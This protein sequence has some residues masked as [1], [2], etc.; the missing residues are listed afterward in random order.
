MHQ[1][2]NTLS[3]KCVIYDAKPIESLITLKEIAGIERK[4]IT[5]PVLQKE[6]KKNVYSIHA[7]MKL[8]PNHKIYSTLIEV[9]AIV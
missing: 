6:A 5:R 3:A 8:S 1:L 2:N 4:N 7:R 9:V